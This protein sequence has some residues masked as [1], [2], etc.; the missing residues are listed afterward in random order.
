MTGKKPYEASEEEKELFLQE[1]KDA[2]RI[3]R[4]VLGLLF[5]RDRRPLLP[6][7]RKEWERFIRAFMK[8][9]LKDFDVS[10]GTE[11]VEGRKR[12]VGPSVMTRL[13]RGEFAVEGSMDLHGLG[14]REAKQKVAEFVAGSRAGGR[15]CVLIIHGRGKRSREGIPVLKPSLVSWLEAASGIGRHILAFATARP[16]D[17]G[18]GAVYVLLDL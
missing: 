1:V 12:G 4:D 10:L 8:G 5:D 13:R 9:S 18:P 7:E 17:G 6:D 2:R 14:R 3:D 11:Y 15:R 16:C